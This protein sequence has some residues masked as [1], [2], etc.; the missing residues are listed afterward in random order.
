MTLNYPPACITGNILDFAMKEINIHIEGLS[1]KF[2][3]FLKG[4]FFHLSKVTGSLESF[5]FCV[6]FASTFQ[7]KSVAVIVFPLRRRRQT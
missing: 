1:K 2:Q 3:M 4:H 5:K 6:I 7:G